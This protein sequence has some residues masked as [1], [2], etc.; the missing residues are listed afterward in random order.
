MKALL[1]YIATVMKAVMREI[2]SLR[3]SILPRT[4][5]WITQRIVKPSIEYAS[6]SCTAA[7]QAVVGFVPDVVRSALK[8]PGQA[9]RGTGAVLEG[10]GRLV[11]ATLR[12]AAAVPTALASWPCRRWQMPP[13]LPMAVVVERTRRSGHRSLA[14]LEMASKLPAGVE[15][16]AD[17]SGH[18]ASAASASRLRPSGVG[19]SPDR[20]RVR[21]G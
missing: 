16:R 11:G 7:A 1:A 9:L 19:G 10:G 20:A 6:Q 5:R 21:R 2:A 18:P 14:E 4:G 15:S 13:G 17:E 12:A 8:L 3:S